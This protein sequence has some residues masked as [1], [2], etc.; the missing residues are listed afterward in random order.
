MA[1]LP[2]LCRH[3][4]GEDLLIPS[5]ATW[6]CGQKPAE[7]YVREHFEALEVRPAFRPYRAGAPLPPEKMRELLGFA[8]H[9]W[10]AQ[11]RV[12]LSTVPCWEDGALVP[13]P[14]VLRVYL[15]ATPGGG[16][17]VMP[18]GLT[19]VGA[20]PASTRVTMQHGGASKDTWVLSD[21]PVEEVSLLHPPGQTLELRRV[22]NNLPSRLADNYFWLGRY[23][24]RADATGRLLRSA[25]LRFNPESTGSAAPLL[26]PLLQALQDQGQIPV[27]RAATAEAL[28]AALVG[29]VYNPAQ[30]GS[31]RA[32]ADRV[33]Q[34]AVL[35]RDRTSNDVWRAL[36]SLNECVTQATGAPPAL[37]TDAIASINRIVLQ[38]ASIYGLSRENMTRAQG[39]RF[40]DIGQ[41]IERSIYLCT[42]LDRALSSPEADNLS[43]L[44]AILEFADSTITYR[45]RYNLMPGI[46]AVYDLVL[47]DD[48]NPRSLLFQLL[49]LV[50]HFERLPRE[51]QSALPSP[52]QRV[53]IEAVT[54]V[55]LLDPRELIHTPGAWSESETAHV[56]RESLRDLPRLAEAIAVSYFAHSV[57]SRAG[58]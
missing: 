56:I 39:W 24:E 27:E 8:P 11:E 26:A 40:L 12:P 55:R 34:L 28:E 35:V 38:I 2:G 13:R 1:F 44:E 29:A 30:A 57:I 41:R 46:A 31:L 54:R 5:V 33:E 4:L 16:Y 37:A 22:G 14:A 9:L 51:K 6:W 50:K 32:L 18:G 20:D 25:L 52:G 21:T 17:A 7:K 48:T 23:T 58:A 47:L 3:V 49:Q 10:T 19:R 53:L 15:A 36:S 43:V 45:S 42:F